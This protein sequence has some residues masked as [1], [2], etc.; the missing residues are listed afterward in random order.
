MCD[1][2]LTVE[3]ISVESIIVMQKIQRHH[4]RHIPTESRIKN[5]IRYLLMYIQISNTVSLA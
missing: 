2:N 5:L 4:Y 1:S 3:H